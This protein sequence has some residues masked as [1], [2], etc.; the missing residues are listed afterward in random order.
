MW[1]IRRAQ[2]AGPPLRLWFKV[3]GALALAHRSDQGWR[4]QLLGGSECVQA[5]QDRPFLPCGTSALGRSQDPH[6]RSTQCSFPATLLPPASAHQVSMPNDQLKEQYGLCYTGQW[7]VRP[8]LLCAW[9]ACTGPAPA[10]S[11]ALLMCSL[12]A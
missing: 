4:P 7:K 8:S 9:L 2:E 3:G 6:W 10:L 12:A 1:G 5:G 11:C